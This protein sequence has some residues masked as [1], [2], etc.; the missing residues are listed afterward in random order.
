MAIAF[1]AGMS[2]LG[3]KLLNEYVPKTSALPL[4]ADKWKRWA[5]LSMAPSVHRGAPTLVAT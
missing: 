2:A 1:E 3:Q 5:E 4:S